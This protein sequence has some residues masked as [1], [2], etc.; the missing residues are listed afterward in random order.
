MIK[1]VD[2]LL[3]KILGNFSNKMAKEQEASSTWL[4]C[5]QAGSNSSDRLQNHQI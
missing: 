2:D 5:T 3:L 1:T 4:V